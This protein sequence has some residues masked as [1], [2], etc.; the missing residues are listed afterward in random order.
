MMFLGSQS[1]NVEEKFNKSCKVCGMI[2]VT[3]EIWNVI[4]V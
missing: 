4:K 1:M 3:F 2:D